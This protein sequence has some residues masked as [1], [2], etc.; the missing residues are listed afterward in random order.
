[1]KK[2]I[3]PGRT[4]IWLIMILSL[5]YILLTNMDNKAVRL[6]SWTIIFIYTIWSL[7][8]IGLDIDGNK[9]SRD[10]FRLG[11]RSSDTVLKLSSILW[12]IIFIIASI[13]RWADKHL[14]IYSY[15]NKSRT[16]K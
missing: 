2:E 6:I 8:V 15:E 9:L 13:F 3:I 14:T 12:V 10:S 7:I 11:N 5:I 4:F 16:K 1:M